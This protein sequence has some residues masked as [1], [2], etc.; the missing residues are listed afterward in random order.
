MAPERSKGTTKGL[1]VINYV[2]SCVLKS[3]FY[4][5]L[6]PLQLLVT[7]KRENVTVISSN[8]AW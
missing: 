1:R 7:R 2:V 8:I 6:V 4:I 5:V 3:N